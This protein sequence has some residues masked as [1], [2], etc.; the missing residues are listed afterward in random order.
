MVDKAD[1]I[2]AWEQPTLLNLKGTR[3]RKSLKVQEKTCDF[4]QREA[5]SWQFYW[6]NLNGL[7]DEG[8][9]IWRNHFSQWKIKSASCGQWVSLG[10]LLDMELALTLH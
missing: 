8:S 1:K 3:D 6:P 5:K 7:V 4:T 2:E 10:F 9:T